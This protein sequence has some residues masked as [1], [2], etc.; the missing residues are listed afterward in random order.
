[1]LPP[2]RK[3]GLGGKRGRKVP[4]PSQ[5]AR[6]WMSFMCR[7]ESG[8]TTVR[9]FSCSITFSIN[10]IFARFCRHSNTPTFKSLRPF[11]TPT[12]S[13]GEIYS[14]SAD[15]KDKLSFVG[16]LSHRLAMKEDNGKQDSPKKRASFEHSHH[17]TLSGN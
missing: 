13:H 10:A 1:M 6:G 16:L 17:G 3:N 8:K 9:R 5:H 14:Y 12:H 7:S 4:H 15:D 2:R 11:T